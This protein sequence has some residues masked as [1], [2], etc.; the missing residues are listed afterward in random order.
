MGYMN[1]AADC[2]TWRTIM[3]IPPAKTGT[4]GPHKKIEQL[5][6][7]RK[8]LDDLQ[9]RM[10]AEREEILKVVRAQLE[11]MD[12]EYAERLQDAR[13]AGASLEEGAKTAVLQ[14]G[15]S[16]QVGGVHVVFYRGRVTWDSEAL[17]RYAKS[18]P[19]VEKFRKVGEPS[20]VVRY[21][22][23]E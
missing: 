15:K 1:S 11:A 16:V 8:Y 12:E 4:E 5:D 2:V 13:G 6:E 23:P 22:Q 19:E 7:A 20:V 3:S 14:L 21:K 17:A 10:E 9:R 18:N